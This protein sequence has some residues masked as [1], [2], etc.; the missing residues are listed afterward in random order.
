MNYDYDEY[1]QALNRDTSCIYVK[2]ESGNVRIVSPH[3][4]QL[5]VTTPNG[6][7]IE[8]AEEVESPKDNVVVFIDDR[9]YELTKDEHE[10]MMR[11]AKDLRWVKWRMTLFVCYWIV[12]IIFLV[13]VIIFAHSQTKSP[14]A[15]ST[16]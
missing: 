7:D 4:P 3:I 16:P 2:D 5:R 8:I 14:T 1:Y 15:L 11:I 12:W 6:G 13:G 9:V 10:L